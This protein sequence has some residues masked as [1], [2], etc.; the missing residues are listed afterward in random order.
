MG[1]RSR[2]EGEGRAEKA[3]SMD[4]I[5]VRSQKLRGSNKTIY[6][7]LDDAKNIGDVARG[8]AGG[9]CEQ[10]LQRHGGRGLP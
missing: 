1:V 4:A 8:L 9:I 2:G 10:M 7:V 6:H 3:K 5:M